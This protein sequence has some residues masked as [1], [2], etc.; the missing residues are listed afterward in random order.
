M[1]MDAC[2]HYMLKGADSAADITAVFISSDPC[3]SCNER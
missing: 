1:N 3:I 2:A